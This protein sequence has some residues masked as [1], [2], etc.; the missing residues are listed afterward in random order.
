MKGR[1]AVVVFARVPVPGAVKTR[2]AGALSPEGAA[3][4]YE[5]FISDT[6]DSLAECS[7]D[8]T[9]Y[10]AP[11]DQPQPAGLA[12]EGVRVRTQRG[13]DLG[14]RMLN[15]LVETFA[16][17][18]ERIVIVGSDHPTLPAEFFTLALEALE[19]RSSVVIGPADDGGYY[20]IGM[21]ELY[22]GLFREMT[23]SRPDVLDRTL[24]RLADTDANLTLLPPWNDVDTPADLERL[25]RA[26]ES[27]EEKA[28]HTADFL[29]TLGRLP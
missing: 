28:P 1:A 3:G 29:R 10:F 2:L 12:P 14:A 8:V 17:G 22:P 7:A 16:A 20:L 23:F 6:L 21:N 11:G 4:L 5:A 27:G 24:E 18:Y 26:L 19:E 13:D 25:V 15:A 9:L